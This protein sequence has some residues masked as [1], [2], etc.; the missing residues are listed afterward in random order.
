MFDRV[1]NR[2]LHRCTLETRLQVW[3]QDF[4]KAFTR[5]EAIARSVTKVVLKNLQNF[6]AKLTRTHLRQSVFFHKVAGLRQEFS[7]EFCKFL[8][9]MFLHRS[10]LAAASAEAYLGLC[11]TY[12]METFCEN[13][14]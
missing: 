10:P 3:K 7:C 11:Q 1:L 13:D 4:P 5:A 8:K 14:S 12:M 9:K 6:T 2:P